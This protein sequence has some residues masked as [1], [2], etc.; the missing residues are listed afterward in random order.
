MTRARMTPEGRAELRA[1]LR[2]FMNEYS[3]ESEVRRLAETD[4]GFDASVWERMA[5]ELGVQGLC[6]PEELGGAGLGW[7]ELGLVLEEAG[8]ALLCA[9]LLAT[10]R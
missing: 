1:L 4:K 7:E 2:G 5:S 3:A 6:V 10:V 9:P 8:R